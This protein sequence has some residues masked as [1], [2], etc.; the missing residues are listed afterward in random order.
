[1]RRL[2]LILLLVTPAFVYAQGEV[3]Y[4][5]DRVNPY[6]TLHKGEWVG[7][8]AASFGNVSSDNSSILLLFQGIDA[9]G[10]ISSIKPSVGYFY[11]DRRMAGARFAYSKIVGEVSSAIIDLGSANDLELDVPYLKFDNRSYSYGLYHRSYTKVDA[12]GQFELF[13]EI[14]LLYS[15]GSYNIA[16]DLTGSKSKLRNQMSNFS[17]GFNPGLSVNITPNVASFVSFGLGGFSVNHIKQYDEQGELVGKRR[18]SRFNLS[19]D[20]LAID[21]GMTFHFWN[22]KE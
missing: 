20:L 11:S 17:I 21:F 8:I 18:A 10:S 13:A 12:K 2:L 7:S 5:I 14:D 15:N 16:Q 1:M 3:D 22:T 4:K 19:V 9:N 6:Q